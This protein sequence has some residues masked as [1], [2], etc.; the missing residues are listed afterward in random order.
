MNGYAAFLTIRN[1]IR[2][3]TIMCASSAVPYI[4]LFCHQQTQTVHVQ[5]TLF[6][7]SQ[8]KAGVGNQI[9]QLFL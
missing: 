3:I 6:T 7:Q 5:C 8:L 1:L 2:A 9:S 4:S